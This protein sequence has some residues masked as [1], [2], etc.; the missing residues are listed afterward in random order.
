MRT[1]KEIKEKIE[2]IRES[3]FDL[4]E[5]NM[6]RSPSR[7]VSLRSL[8]LVIDAL[9]F[10]IGKKNELILLKDDKDKTRGDIYGKT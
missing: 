4:M 3:A 7:R 10:S 8:R 9:E 2:Q 6:Y 5:K 1:E